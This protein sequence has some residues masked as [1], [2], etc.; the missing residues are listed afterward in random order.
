MAGMLI[1][2][3]GKSRG[4]GPISDI[5]VTP[6]VDVMLVLLIIFMVTAPLL[7][8]GVPVDLPQS[9]AQVISQADEPL[10]ISI[11][12]DGV[13]YLQETETN[14]EGL[15]ARLQ[16]I[17]NNNKESKI[18]VRGDKDIAYGRI[19]EVMGAVT[20]AGFTH[21]ALISQLPEQASPQ[22]NKP[23]LESKSAPAQPSKPKN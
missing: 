14:L 10:V 2:K 7:T 22:K 3:R 21:V 5:N 15:V 9:K 12:K 18:Y 19:V 20:L 1:K 23:A 11:N 17:T 8:V 16:A 6:L 13:V 4:S